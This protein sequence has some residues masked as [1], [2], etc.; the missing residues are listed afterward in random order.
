V[1][2]QLVQS[3]F[4]CDI[5]V[6]CI[7]LWFLVKALGVSMRTGLGV[8]YGRPMRQLG[9]DFGMIGGNRS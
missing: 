6:H 7:D 9:F 8:A 1:Y 2:I 3:V 5:M 4:G